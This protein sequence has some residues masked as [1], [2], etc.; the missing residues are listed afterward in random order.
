MRKIVLFL[1]LLATPSFA[2]DRS[3]FIVE[4]RGDVARAKIARDIPRVEQQFGRVFSGAAA[5]LDSAEAARIAKLPYVRRVHVD[6]R[7]EA[8]VHDSVPDMRVPQVW[9]TH[10]SRGSG[11]TVAIIDT[12]IDYEHPALQGRV[13]GGFDFVNSDDD[14]MDDN[15]HGT[16]VAGIVAAVAPDAKLLAYK[17]LNDAGAGNDSDVIAAI[18]LAMDPNQDGDLSDRADVINLSLGR[19]GLPDDAAVTAVENAIFFGAVVV[20]AA[21]N[22]SNFFMIGSPGLAPSAIT[23]GA[24][25]R[26]HRLAPFSSKGPSPQSLLLKP[27]VVAPGTQIVSAKLGGGEIAHSG[28]SMATPHVAGV[29]ALLR[30]IHPTW[31]VAEIKSALVTTTIGGSEEA[32]AIGAGRVDALAAS[33]ATVFASPAALTFGRTDGSD[34]KWTSTVTVTLHNRASSAR[35]LSLTGATGTSSAI[36]LTMAPVTLAPDETKTVPVTIEVT[37]ANVFAPAGGSLS[38]GGIVT[39]AG[40]GGGDET[41]RLPWAFVKAARVRVNWASEA[42]FVLTAISKQMKQRVEGSLAADMILP[43]DQYM[44]EVRS[45]TEEG[46]PLLVEYEAVDARRD[47]S[48]DGSPAEAKN[49]IEFEVLP[50]RGECTR[51]LTLAWPDGYVQTESVTDSSSPRFHVSDLA[52]VRGR[53]AEYCFD[54]LTH[55]LYLSGQLLPATVDRGFVVRYAPSDWTRNPVRLAG[56]A[57][58]VTVLMGALTRETTGHTFMA[59]SYTIPFVPSFTLYMTGDVLPHEGNAAAFHYG[60]V[61]SPPLRRITDGLTTSIELNLPPFANVVPF[62]ATVTLGAGARWPRVLMHEQP[63]VEWLGL[64]GEVYTLPPAHELFDDRLEASAPGSKLTVRFDKQRADPVAPTLTSVRLL[65]EGLVF[66]AVDFIRV[67]GG[68]ARAPID[69]NSV[70]VS[71]RVGTGAWM[72]LPVAAVDGYYRADLTTA[73]RGEISVRVSFADPAGNSTEWVGNLTLGARKRRSV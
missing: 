32:M 48:L 16:H 33:A 27:E 50:G 53:V 35:T 5:T 40:G 52:A 44:F 11:Q 66:S 14:P 10:G 51:R 18:E 69:A 37:N 36:T 1:F 58:D 39:I 7:V 26:E 30:A 19:Q 2:A 17:V 12:G 71:W 55:S 3:R 6:G 64:L 59:M 57:N 45:S 56:E 49:V 13:I 28:T 20:V 15:G 8:Q 63:R 46:E 23:V 38:Y 68:L 70:A 54:E 34:A 31:S 61:Q 24:I 21:G 60:N 9:Q 25:D 62:G 73:P 41:L 4:F 72:P 67:E 22:D 43:L 65:P 47:V 42:S 29:A